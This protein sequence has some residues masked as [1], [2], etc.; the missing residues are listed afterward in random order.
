MIYSMLND[1][2]V[3][4]EQGEVIQPWDIYRKIIANYADKFLN[5][6]LLV[7]PYVV[8]QLQNDFSIMYPFLM[9]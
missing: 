5:V 3:F 6:I 7:I 8:R 9:C 4:D 1:N 2:L